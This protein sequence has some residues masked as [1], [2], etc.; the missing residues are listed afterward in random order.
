MYRKFHN[1]DFSGFLVAG[2]GPAAVDAEAG[3]IAPATEIQ[4]H[5]GMGK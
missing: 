5:S 1:A 3:G 4:N 2:R